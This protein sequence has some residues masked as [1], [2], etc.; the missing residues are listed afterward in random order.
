MLE[1]TD[2]TMRT[3]TDVLVRTGVEAATQ[4]DGLREVLPAI[5][6]SAHAIAMAAERISAVVDVVRSRRQPAKRETN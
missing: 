1:K 2:A 5:E 4:T 3:F 6:T